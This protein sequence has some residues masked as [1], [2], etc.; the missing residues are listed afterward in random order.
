MPVSCCV[1]RK[2]L[3]ADQQQKLA[4]LI[5]RSIQFARENHSRAMA[6]A[7][8]FSPD[9]D[10]QVAERFV[11]QYVNDLSVDMGSQGQAALET[12]FTQAEIAGILPPALPLGIVGAV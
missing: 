9:S 11:R 2:D 3:P 6:H 12:F 4:G 1:V 8:D 5:R 10:S 7:K